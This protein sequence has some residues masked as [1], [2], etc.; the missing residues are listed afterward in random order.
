MNP[1]AWMSGHMLARAVGLQRIGLWSVRLQP[2]K[3]SF[4]YHRHHFEEE[5]MYVLSGR[6]TVEIDG[7]SHEI[8]PGDFVGFQTGVAHGL[9]NTGSEDL[10]YLSGGENRDF[11]VGD[12]PREG[13]RMVRIKDRVDVYAID[14]G[15]A[16]PGRERI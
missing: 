6:G 14:D 7:E 15:D 1:N 4:I 9:R 10:V 16:F 3:E 8:G 12:F 13:K 5:F 11:E 2:G